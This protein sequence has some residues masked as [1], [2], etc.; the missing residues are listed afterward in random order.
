MNIKTIF[1]ISLL[2][3]KINN[4]K[5]TID[6][7]IYIT[8]RNVN[9]G[10]ADMGILQFKFNKQSIK[11]PFEERTY[12]TKIKKDSVYELYYIE[13]K[14]R[15]SL[16]FKDT[17]LDSRNHIYKKRILILMNRNQIDSIFIDREYRMIYKNKAY[18]INDSL[19]SYLIKIMP[20]DIK[21][22]WIYNL[23]GREFY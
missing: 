2:L 20:D 14:I 21:S 22:N 23:S 11:V 12:E 1:L 6:C 10:W 17:I 19:K 18:F 5:D 8:P 9:Y 15:E 4:Y 16:F 7:Q 3:C 13:D